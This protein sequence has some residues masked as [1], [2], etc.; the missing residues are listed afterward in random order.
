MATEVGLMFTL[1]ESLLVSLTIVPPTGAGV[2]SA[3]TNGDVCPGAIEISEGNVMLPN[4]EMVI[5]A[6]AFVTLWVEV[7]VVM[8]ADPG[9]TAVTKNVVEVRPAPMVTLA[10]TETKE[11]SV[12]S[13]KLNPADGA[14]IEMLKVKAWL[15]PATIVA[16]AGVKLAK[17]GVG[18]TTTNE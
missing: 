5:D 14:G 1:E 4:G 10:G 6:E 18:G 16:K 17:M 8:I 7:V 3:I 13:E 9:E 12:I 15:A 2:D 11:G